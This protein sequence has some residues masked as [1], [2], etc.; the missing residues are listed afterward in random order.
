MSN[1]MRVKICILLVLPLLLFGCSSFISQ[2]QAK[3]TALL[4]I[5]QNVKFYATVANS[6]SLVEEAK[7]PT[8]TSYKEGEV[9]IVVAHVTSMVNN[10]EK[11]NDLV[12]KVDKQGKVI[13]FNGQKI[14]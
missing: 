13:E 5:S 12:I 4:F 3:Q 9:W 7:I 6:S 2:E 11:K 8:T 10:T 14:A 1:V